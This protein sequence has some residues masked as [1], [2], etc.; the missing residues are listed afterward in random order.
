M[1]SPIPLYTMLP[2]YTFIC[3]EFKKVE[4]IKCH[5]FVT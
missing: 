2:V 5:L 4:K 1:L 3:S